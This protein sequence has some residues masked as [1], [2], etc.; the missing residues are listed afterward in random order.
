MTPSIVSQQFPVRPKASQA[1]INSHDLMLSLQQSNSTADKQAIVA[2]NNNSD[3]NSEIGR[4]SANDAKMKKSCSFTGVGV[5]IYVPSIVAQ[6]FPV[7]PSASQAG[8]F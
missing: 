2:M 8:I 4:R 5:C 3:N 6:Q 1:G 7:S